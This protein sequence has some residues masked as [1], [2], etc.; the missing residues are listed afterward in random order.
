MEPR[1]TD[2]A[3]RPSQARGFPG[4]EPFEAGAII[5]AL[6]R[7]RMTG[8]PGAVHAPRAFEAFQEFS[9]GNAMF[10]R[11]WVSHHAVL[12]DSPRLVA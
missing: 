8:G 5:R 1:T 11:S 12:D 2:K 4:Q 10:M 3:A 9:H 6:A 7:P